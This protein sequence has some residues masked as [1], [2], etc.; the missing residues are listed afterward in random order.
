[1]PGRVRIDQAALGQRLPYRDGTF[2]L[3]VCA[4]AIHYAPDR[5]AAFAEFFRVLRPGGAAAAGSGSRL[6]KFTRFTCGVVGAPSAT[7]TRDLLLRRQLLYPLSYRGPQPCQRSGP[8]GSTKG[9]PAAAGTG[10]PAE[11]GMARRR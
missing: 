8:A 4:L 2:D 3:V 7:R 10:T 1:M 11:P 5:G 6:A 9:N